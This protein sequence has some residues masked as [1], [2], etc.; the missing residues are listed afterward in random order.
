[1]EK[2]KWGGDVSQPYLE[3]YLHSPTE[4]IA[5]VELIIREFP[6][7]SPVQFTFLFLFLVFRFLKFYFEFHVQIT[8]SGQW[9]PQYLSNKKSIPN[10]VCDKYVGLRSRN[11]MFH[12]QPKYIW[13]SKS[14]QPFRSQFLLYP[15]YKGR[16]SPCNMVNAV[17]L[18]ASYRLN[19]LKGQRC[20]VW[21]RSGLVLDTLKIH[22]QSNYLSSTTSSLLQTKQPEK[23][24]LAK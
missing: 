21:S 10:A 19:L 18:Y 9:S 1:M 23:N 15:R 13:I 14:G 8:P 7:I 22:K 6:T 24:S 16:T 5:G 4:K 17:R 12:R 11:W 2:I 20:M 3:W